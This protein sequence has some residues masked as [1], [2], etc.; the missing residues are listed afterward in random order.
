MLR[1]LVAL[2]FTRLCVKGFNVY[3]M[4]ELVLKARQ[5]DDE[6]INKIVESFKEKVKGIA[7]GYFLIGGDLDDLV[8]EGMIGLFKAI[9][10]FDDKKSSDFNAFALMCVNRQII[11][12]IKKYNTDKNKMLNYT[13]SLDDVDERDLCT[14]SPESIAI[15]KESNLMLRHLID[16]HLSKMERQVVLAFFEGYS[17]GEIALQ[18]KVTTKS[19]DNALQRA[20]QKLSKILQR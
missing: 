2:W 20:R 19:V 12:C 5:G 6:A 15:D 10:S 7:R 13:I 1:L 11:N 17:Y 3:K 14:I 8:Q 18:L 9:N 4:K 16:E